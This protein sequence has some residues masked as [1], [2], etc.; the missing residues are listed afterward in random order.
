MQVETSTGVAATRKLP[1]L[2]FPRRRPEDTALYRAVC[3]NLETFLARAEQSG[4]S[5][6]RF[7]VREL[8]A[9]LKCGLLPF[10]FVR[11][12]CTQCG[13]ERLVAFSCKGRGIC[14]SCVGRR[15]ADTAAHLVDRVVPEVPVRQWVLSLP[16]ALRLRMAYDSRL[17][18]AV[19]SL[20]VRGIFDALRRRARRDFGVANGRC[21]AVTFVQRFGDALNLNVHF[22]SLVLDGVYVEGPEGVRFRPLPPPSDAEIERVARGLARRLMRLLERRGLLEEEVQSDP[23]LDDSV[24]LELAAASVQGRVASGSRA[25]RRV[26]R[27]GDRIDPDDLRETHAPL[28]A[29]VGGVS[30][31]AGVAVP[32]RD[33]RRL[34]RLC[35]YVARPPIASERL[36]AQDDGRLLYRL[37]RRWRDG[38]T[39]VLFEPIELVERIAA[40]IPP[41]RA[42]LVRYHGELAPAARRRAR[43]VRDRVPLAPESSAVSAPAQAPAPGA[44]RSEDPGHPSRTDSAADSRQS[45]ASAYVGSRCRPDERATVPASHPSSASGPDSDGFPRARRLSW[46]QLMQRVFLV[47]VLECP[48][49]AG[50]MRL[51]AAI[52]EPRVVAR[53]LA[54]LGLPARAPPLRPAPADPSAGSHDETDPA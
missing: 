24:L 26:L 28:C 54:H 1:T 43:V 45:G 22:H 29:N 32:A 23:A 5:V 8:R 18:S 41:P 37:K 6:P 53:I 9:Y 49:C 20:H 15:M 51:V 30:L 31:H 48:V 33:R 21:G 27:L 36:S 4:R 16:W 13:V 44:S 14:P 19:L 11:V 3:E 25:G 39:H 47:D 46:A 38:T 17:C 34:E 10:G 40:L 52:V 50:R 7:V 12:R 2:A 42:H 35:R